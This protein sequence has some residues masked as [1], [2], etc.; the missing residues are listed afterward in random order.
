MSALFLLFKKSMPQ[1]QRDFL[2]SKN[3][4]FNW[5]LLSFLAGNVDVGGYMACRRFVTHVT[6]FATLIGADIAKGEWVSSLSMFSVPLFFIAGV[7]ISAWLTERRLQLGLK[8]HFAIAMALVTLCLFLAGLGG[9]CG[10]FGQFGGEPSVKSDYLFLCLLCMASGLQNAIVTSYSASVVRTTHLTG[11][12][13]DL[14]IGLIRV[15][16]PTPDEGKLALERRFN[17]LRIGTIFAFIAGAIMGAL[18][19]SK[20]AYLGFLLP[21]A[22]ALYAVFAAIYVWQTPQFIQAEIKF[23]SPVDI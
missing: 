3:H 19:Y 1:R 20:F 15:L 14:G 7:M 21:T 17:A 22:I 10:W 12:T 18:V 8:P 16:F 2:Y 13:T 6:G 23:K 11:I 4:F 9:V 5:F